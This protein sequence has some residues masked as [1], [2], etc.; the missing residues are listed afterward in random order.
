MQQKLSIPNDKLHVVHIGVNPDIYR[1]SEPASS[2]Q[3]IGYL[4][5]ISEENG[6]EVLVDA[7][8]SLKKDPLFE[9][10]KLKVTGG[11]TDHDKAFIH[12]QIKKLRYNNLLADIEFF[13]KFNGED[14]ES[15][16]STLSVLSV[17]VLKG[18]AFGLYQLEALASGV[19][20]VQPHLGA[21]PEV[22]EASRGGV[23]YFPNTAEK[24]SNKMKEVLSDKQKLSEMSKAGRKAVEEKFN[25]TLL[26]NHL[27][28]IYRSL[29]IN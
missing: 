15:F 25:T 1:Y 23:T 9:K 21:F 19:P 24:L 6:F 3:A 20:L 13:D 26:T 11:K 27:I 8:I 4:S 22:L 28:E 17:P 2:P 7:F 10:L 16:F 29:G 14:L 18:E 5:R 12:K